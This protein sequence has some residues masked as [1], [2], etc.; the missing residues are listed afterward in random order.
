MLPIKKH[1]VVSL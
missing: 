1:L